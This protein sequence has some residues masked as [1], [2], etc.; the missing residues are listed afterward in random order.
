MSFITLDYKCEN[1]GMIEERFVRKSERDE[2]ECNECIGPAGA[3]HGYPMKALPP[4]PI[5]NFKFGD[6]A[7][8]KS[9]KAVSL[10]D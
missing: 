3:G 9:K 2:Q 7:A 10:R 6:R 8:I 5:T 4:G 1:C